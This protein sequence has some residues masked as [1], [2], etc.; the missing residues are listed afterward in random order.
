MKPD[1]NGTP[2][3]RRAIRLKFGNIEVEIRGY[4][5]LLILITLAI[6]GLGFAAWEQREGR[7]TAVSR[8]SIEH[9]AMIESMRRQEEALAELVYVGSLSA[10]QR[11]LLKIGMPP[12]L[13][14]KIVSD[15]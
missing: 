14:K 8:I 3:K 10:E 7:Q 6:G 5:I 12:S 4:D 13:R 15:R 11:A 1:D 9:T 2:S